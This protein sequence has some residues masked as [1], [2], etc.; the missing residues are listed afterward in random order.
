MLGSG[1]PRVDADGSIAG[2]IGSCIDVTAIRDAREAL[3]KSR[4]ELGALVNQRTA[5]LVASNAQLRAEIAHRAQI[6]EE[7]TRIRRIES[8]EVL[9]GGI[10][11][12]FNNL[13]TVI[14]GRSQLLR[15]ELG[16]QEAAQR[17]LE[18]IESTAQRACVLTQQL[19][20][21]GRKQ[22]LQ[23]RVVSINE[24]VAGLPL[25]SLV[26]GAVELTLRLDA[27]LRPSSLDPGHIESLILQLVKNAGEAMPEGG[28]LVVETSNVDLD[29]EFV[30]SHPGARAGAYARLSIRDAGAGMDEATRRHIFEP[31]FTA[32]VGAPGSGLGLA[33]VYGITKQHGG[34]IT[35]ESAPG[36]GTTFAIYLPAAEARPPA[37]VVAAQG[38]QQR[39]GTETVLLVDDEQDV[40]E[41]MR[42]ILEAHGYRVVEAGD[43]EAALAL[44]A[45]SAEP[46]DLILADVQMPGMSGPVLVERIAAIRPG[47]KALYVSGYSA[48]MLSRQGVLEADIAFVEKPFTVMSLR[49]DPRGARRVTPV[50]LVRDALP[51]RPRALGAVLRAMWTTRAALTM[52][53]A[54]I[55]VLAAALR[56]WRLDQN[57][58][59]NEYYAAA[60][61][62]M[63]AS[64]HAFVY[65]SF[66]PAGFVSVD[67]PPLALWIQV[68]SAKLLGF[69]GLACSCPRCSRAWRRCGCV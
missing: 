33:A 3:E 40:R 59:G 56:V 60:V 24:L 30:R 66:D 17:E 58:F 9:A 10:A 19:L 48:E 26:G 57:G 39:G 47:V 18:G 68:A 41:L 54:G 51:D 28:R 32:R 11:H 20:S 46:I 6:E 63:M 55:L 1:V 38:L 15:E 12:E 7:V 4:D 50:R 64:G 36:E 42:D 35:V 29:E 49:Q 62:S 25:A 23:P 21:F 31:F 53:R 34:Y 22:L 2:F 65:N 44:S 5:E 45:Q 16:T 37:A 69:D 14:L 43:P 8:L 61:R 27:S 13:L 52:A 67:K